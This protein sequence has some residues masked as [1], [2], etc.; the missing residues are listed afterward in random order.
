[1]NN[2]TTVNEQDMVTYVYGIASI[3]HEVNRGYCESL[4]DFTIQ[5]WE[6]ASA[7]IKQN[8]MNGVVF[9]LSNPLSTP[10][11]MHTN[12]VK[13]KTR[14]GWVYGEVKDAERL[15]HPCI[16]PYE[17]LPQEQRTKDNIFMAVV[18]SSRKLFGI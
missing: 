9:R 14:A 16:V 2:T 3:C 6:Q 7:D 18:D 17:S 12:W 10:K 8:A 15:T 13:D 4:G 5:P 11:D 1:M